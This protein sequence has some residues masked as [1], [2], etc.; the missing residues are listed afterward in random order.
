MDNEY[1]KIYDYRKSLLNT[2]KDLM[3]KVSRRGGSSIF[4]HLL[5]LIL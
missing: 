5:P 4:R 3:D 1:F 2:L